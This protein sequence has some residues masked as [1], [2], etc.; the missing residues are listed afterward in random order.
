MRRL[1]S[2]VP[3]VFAMLQGCG[4]TVLGRVSDRDA[5]HSHDRD[6]G[7]VDAEILD[8]GAADAGA[9]DSGVADLGAAD[10]SGPDSG[11]ADLGV[12]DGGSQPARLPIM[13]AASNYARAE[14]Q[15]GGLGPFYVYAWA[16][17]PAPQNPMQY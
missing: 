5:S 2:F 4:E 11:V 14:A 6:T 13:I 10:S 7:S 16:A 15:L 9:A 1:S 17:N 3:I 12:A 8:S